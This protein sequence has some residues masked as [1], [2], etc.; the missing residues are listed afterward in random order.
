VRLDDHVGGKGDRGLD[1]ADLFIDMKAQFSASNLA[2][3]KPHDKAPNSLCNHVLVSFA[4]LRSAIVPHMPEPADDLTPARAEDLR[5][6]IAFALTS[7]SRLAKAQSADFMASIGAERLIARLVR[8]GFVVLR[9]P[10]APGAAALRR[11][12]EG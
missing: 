7:D 10:P 5:A 2:R 4:S 3:K 8:D 12:F 1:P 11:G 6:F 9:R